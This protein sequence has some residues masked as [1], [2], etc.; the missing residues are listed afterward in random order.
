LLAEALA[1][2]ES[3]SSPRA[4]RALSLVTGFYDH[5]SRVSALDANA[6]RPE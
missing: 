5:A 3:E 6:W 2:G 1:P 4:R